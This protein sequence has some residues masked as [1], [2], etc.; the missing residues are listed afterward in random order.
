VT[1]SPQGFVVAEE[2]RK[3]AWQNGYRR[4]LGEEGGW[5]L[6]GSTTAKGSIA[7]AGESNTGPWYLAVDHLGVIEELAL[8]SATVQ[9]PGGVR[10]AFATLAE[11]YE[12]LTKVYALAVSLPD[13]PLE[14]FIAAVNDLP[15]AT[16]AERLV[17]QRVGQDIFRD[18]LMTYWGG[19]CPLTD[20]KNPQLLRASHIKPW[21][22][23]NDD[24]ERLDVHN[25]LLLSALWDA[26]FD[27]GLVSFDDDGMPIFSSQLDAQA[28]VEFRWKNPIKL[29][30]LHRP[31]L[32]WHREWIFARLQN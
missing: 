9:G 7:L 2:C 32:A 12:V 25:G 5:A 28:Q 6:F 29:T 3:A 31:K 23:C 4:S 10:Y 16:E 11:L 17:V 8:P 26:A 15:R 22:R 20:I 24:A 21:A 13:G 14:A 27:A 19:R 18:R 30:D 1:Q